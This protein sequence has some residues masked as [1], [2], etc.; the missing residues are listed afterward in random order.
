MSNAAR[1]TIIPFEGGFNSSNNDGHI[2]WSALNML[3]AALCRLENSNYLNWQNP[4]NRIF[5]KSELPKT[6][7][8]LGE[9]IGLQNIE[10]LFQNA[11][12]EGGIK[13]I[14][15]NNSGFELKLDLRSGLL[16]VTKTAYSPKL[17]F[18]N[19]AEVQF[20]KSALNNDKV[21]LFQQPIIDAK[22]NSCI[23]YECLARA[24]KDD[25]NIALPYEF[26]PAA[27]RSGLIKELDLRS[28]QIAIRILKANPN[29]AFATN[30]SFA[31]INDIGAREEIYSTLASCGLEQGR[32]TVEITE[33][34][35][36]HDFDLARG[37]C[38]K[39]RG[40]GAR[41]SIDDFGSGHTSF[42][43]LRELPIDEV[44]L[45]G[46]YVDKI[47]ERKDA[48]HFAC[49]IKAICSDKNIETLAERVE[50]KDELDEL[51]KI[52]VHSLQGYY[53]GKPEKRF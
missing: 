2:I 14:R 15:P 33:T 25:G 46:Q 28:L 11:Q 51:L 1:N 34:I 20:L 29:A 5:A 44:K 32:L 42:R 4:D 16:S 39:V 36:I 30:V 7:K 19:D 10:E 12:I 22:T 6:L 49:A 50:T 38:E 17:D 9:K 40:F 24:V 48:Y 35:A 26:I 8:E 18:S 52:G 37:F 41:M 13:T 3:E 43:S 23:R 21:I 27:E 53:F 45:D 31:T 47:H